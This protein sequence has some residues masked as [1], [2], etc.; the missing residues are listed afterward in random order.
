LKISSAYHAHQDKSSC[1]VSPSRDNVSD[2]AS[3]ELLD[4]Q[5]AEVTMSVVI[6]VRLITLSTM[7]FAR[8]AQSIHSALVEFR[9]N[10]LLVMYP[11][12]ATPALAQ[13]LTA[14]H[15]RLAIDSL[16]APVLHAQP[17]K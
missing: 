10:A 5:H 12:T 15:A 11:A 1:M 6:H 8:N 4:V 9:M 2:N 13:Q 3:M 17:M 16:E 14:S 7:G